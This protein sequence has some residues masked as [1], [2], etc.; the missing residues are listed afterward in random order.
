MEAG[1]Q[2][3]VVDRETLLAR[4]TETIN[5]DW[6][7]R[8]RTGV[9][10]LEIRQ[11]KRIQVT[12]GY[13]RTEAMLRELHQ[14]LVAALPAKDEVFYHGREEFTIVLAGLRVAEQL[15]L[16]INKIRRVMLEPF[17]LHDT[18]MKVGAVIGAT[19]VEDKL[20]YAD[21]LLQQANLALLEA[22]D[23]QRE[24]VV[25]SDAVTPAEIP[26]LELQSLLSDALER[27][28]LA[29]VYQPK[30]E[31]ATG[32]VVGVEALSRWNSHLLGVVPPDR[33]VD[34]AEKSGLIGKLTT[35]TI[36]NAA[37]QYSLWGKNAVPIAINVSAAVIN[38]PDLLRQLQHALRIWGMPPEAMSLEI[39]ETAVMDAPE[40]SL[41][42][43]RKFSEM[44]HRL[45]IDDF[46]TG[47]SSLAYLKM[48]PV[49]DLKIDKSFVQ[50][51]ANDASDRKIV[52][53][54]ID[55]AHNFDL[56][57]IAEGIEDEASY[58]ILMD[59][60]CD[61]AQGYLISKPLKPGQ[62][63]KWLQDDDWYRPMESGD[64][65]RAA[66]SEPVVLS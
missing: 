38:Q 17:I 23:Q 28:E 66:D 61:I 56:K 36:N 14:R 40:Q 63:E 2:L 46:G 34:A 49:S 9:L 15:H 19:I 52:K 41:E 50:G 64:V 25:F 55:M 7:V 12:Y 33:F 45:A 31:I 22:L 37:K 30:T 13:D 42:S 8:R 16:A 57:V 60:G 21:N 5:R 32:R 51:L 58:Q 59:M 48:L 65:S 11:F 62:F 35:W 27:N 39:T 1:N 3:K 54:I 53:S 18:S 29:T 26:G 10:V 44:G 47:Y 20:V 4:L 43:L 24:T 6:G